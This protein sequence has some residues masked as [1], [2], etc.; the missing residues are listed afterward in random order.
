DSGSLE[1]TLNIHHI[2]IQVY[3]NGAGP[4]WFL[5]DSGA[6][7]SILEK[8]IADSLGMEDAGNLPAIGV[9]GIDVGNFV[10]ADS[11]KLGNVTLLDFAAGAL[12]LSFADN[13]LVQPIQGILG[14]DLFSRLIVDIDY[15]A[16][17]ITIYDP[18]ADI[19]PGRADTLE[20]EIETNHPVI[21]A[22]VNDS[23]EGR[24]R[25]DTGSSNFLD[26]N[27]PFVK[28][29]NLLDNVVKELGTFPIMGIGG[30]SESTIA[31]LPAFTIGKYRLDNLMT[32]FN[33]MET[34]IFAAEN[35][36]GNIGGGIMKWFA[37]GFDYPENKLYLTKIVEDDSDDAIISSG[38]LLKPEG[39]GFVV[40]KI[41]E[42]TPAADSGLQEN[43]KL[44]AV[45]GE[46]VAGLKPD[47]VYEMLDG[48]E[49][50]LVTIEYEREGESIEV[51]LELEDLTK[52]K[53]E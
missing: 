8:R 26:L 6:G 34:G 48:D 36:D 39:D 3:V 41:I 25:F 31:I 17:L 43:D 30:E 37:L 27:A 35:I 51:Q 4:F 32:G 5:L 46:K 18:K 45:N 11:L 50:D 53:D 44:I 22:F 12:D 52:L 21:K 19:Y 9:G 20:L 28:K 13:M 24:F 42:G 15:P 33:Q 1:F 2:Y 16:N 38:L 10:K 7:M 40:Y 23:I 47:A 29:N 14:Y 49:G